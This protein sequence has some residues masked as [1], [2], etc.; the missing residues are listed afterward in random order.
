MVGSWGQEQGISMGGLVTKTKL[1]PA[2]CSGTWLTLWLLPSRCFRTAI[3]QPQHRVNQ[4]TC[5]KLH[6]G[7]QTPGAKAHLCPFIRILAELFCMI[8]TKL[9][10]HLLITFSFLKDAFYYLFETVTGEGGSFHV[11]FHSLKWPQWPSQTGLR[12]LEL[13]PNLLYGFQ[14][15]RT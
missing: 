2:T 3:P 11:L 14:C 1:D 5:L 15:T 8:K 4:C 9:I 10:R 13:L 12:S 6:G 7:P